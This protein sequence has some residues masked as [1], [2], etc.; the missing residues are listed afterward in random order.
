MS[1]Q[2]RIEQRMSEL[3]IRLPD[4]RQP[5]GIYVPAVTSG[6][7]VFTSGTGCRIAADRFL[8]L[9]RV[10]SDLTIQQAQDAARTA[11]INVLAILKEHLGQLDRIERIVRLTGFVNSAHDFHE[12][13]VVVNGASRLLE[14]VF[15]EK[16]R[17]ARSAIGTSNLPFNMPV[18]IEL[19]VEIG[20]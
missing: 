15:Q 16:G 18:E 6:S 9:G 14:E 10:G 11:A 4:V 5:V 3:G 17:H 13:P 20:T 19:I 12:Q 7:L 8:Y 1:G 2:D